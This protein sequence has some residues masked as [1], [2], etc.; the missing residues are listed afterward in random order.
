MI[1]WDTSTASAMPSDLTYR[2]D[3]QTP[4]D[5]SA[6]TAGPKIQI[7]SDPVVVSR[8]IDQAA[9]SSQLVVSAGTTQATFSTTDGSGNLKRFRT[10]CPDGTN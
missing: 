4:L 5:V 7:V 3:G 2:F 8:F 6:S 10:A 9:Y 1:T